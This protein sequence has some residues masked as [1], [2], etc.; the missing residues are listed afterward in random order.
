MAGVEVFQSLRVH[1]NQRD[2][3]LHVDHLQDG[4]EIG[5]GKGLSCKEE[6]KKENRQAMHI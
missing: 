1:T 3:K 5:T 2:T 6:D 4:Y